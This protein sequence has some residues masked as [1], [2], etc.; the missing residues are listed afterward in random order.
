MWSKR[1]N[2]CCRR[3]ENFFSYASGW[4]T[5]KGLISRKSLR[6][7]IREEKKKPRQKGRRES[8]HISHKSSTRSACC[9]LPIPLQTDGCVL[10]NQNPNLQQDS[11]RAPLKTSPNYIPSAVL[12][13]LATAP[14][15]PAQKV[16]VGLTF[17][18]GGELG[19]RQWSV[20]YVVPNSPAERSG[21]VQSGDVCLRY[22]MFDPACTLRCP[23]PFFPEW[24]VLT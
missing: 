8:V 7:V 21:Q 11:V 6:V 1:H 5:F 19:S 15:Q 13:S 17:S 24:T 9:L 10:Q 12:G 14:E 20:S 3:V 2:F 18:R 22:R 4:E 23:S 16:G